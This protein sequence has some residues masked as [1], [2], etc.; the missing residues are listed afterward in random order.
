MLDMVVLWMNLWIV[1]KGVN[2]SVLDTGSLY[3]RIYW[4]VSVHS[5]SMLQVECETS[6]NKSVYILQRMLQLNS[7]LENIRCTLCFLKLKYVV[8]VEDIWFIPTRFILTI[9][10]NRISTV[11]INLVNIRMVIL[12]NQTFSSLCHFHYRSLTTVCI[13]GSRMLC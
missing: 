10:T 11:I 1:N 5:T 9:D 2:E 6:A 13:A 8:I 3:S 12:G 4:W 7:L